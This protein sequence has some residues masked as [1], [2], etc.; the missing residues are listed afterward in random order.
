MLRRSRISTIADT[1]SRLPGN[2]KVG[3]LLTELHKQMENRSTLE[4]AIHPQLY[5]HL[6]VETVAEHLFTTQITEQQ[7]EAFISQVVDGVMVPIVVDDD[8]DT[9]R[10]TELEV[11][12]MDRLLVGLFSLHAIHL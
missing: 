8:D 4:K 12:L 6:A 10:Y 3:T 5:S 11:F 9:D 1:L 7:R 2:P